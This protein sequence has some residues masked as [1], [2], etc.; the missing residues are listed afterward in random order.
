MDNQTGKYARDL[1]QEY[2]NL[3][4]NLT[5]QYVQLKQSRPFLEFPELARA[6]WRVNVLCDAWR[7]ITGRLLDQNKYQE[8]GDDYERTHP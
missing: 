1:F 6:L 3:A 5:N 4:Q 8:G 7:G 2:R